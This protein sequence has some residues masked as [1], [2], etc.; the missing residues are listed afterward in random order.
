[1]TTYETVIGLETHVQLATESKAFCDDRNAFG[2]EP[3]AHISP[4]SLGYPGTLPFLN[5][6]QVAFAVKLGLALGCQI[7]RRSTFDRKNYFYADLPKGYQITQDESPICVGGQLPIRIAGSEP[8]SI[9]LHHIHMEEDAGKS[10]HAE[11]QDFSQVDLNRAGTPLLEIV[12]EPDLRSAEEVD[13]FMSGM[14]QL[15]RWL[16]ISDGN[17]EEGSL[18]C[19]VNISVRPEG[20]SAYGT[21]CEIKNMNSM[22][23]ARR[24][25]AFE[26]DRQIAL[27][28]SGGTVAQQTRQFDPESGTTSALRTKEN[29]HDY[30][31]FPDPDLPPVVVSEEDI[32]RLRA[33][34]GTLPWEAYDELIALGLDADDAALISEDRQRYATFRRYAAASPAVP[35]LAKL[36][37]NRVLPHTQ[38]AEPALTPARFAALQ[39]LIAEGK[40]SAANAASRLLPDL[41]DTPGDPGERATAL[42]LIQNTDINFLSDIAREVVQANPQKAAAYRKGKKGLI[43]FFMGEVMK[44]S[45]GAAEPRETQALLRNILESQA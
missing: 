5:E 21:R 23:F 35:E 16:D 28:E 44:K 24:A 42:G 19:D 12:T 26:V 9:Q 34:I 18:R 40:V 2:A 29:A 25:I 39:Q 36:W 17:M 33:E 43:G 14:R 7:N 38:D 3:N 15:V 41:L 45:G 11:G 20:Q 4:V 10:I 32:A 31:Y 8:R 27:L 30:R 37:V 6:R 13:A 1:M 22:R